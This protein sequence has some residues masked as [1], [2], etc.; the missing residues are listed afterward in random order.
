MPTPGYTFCSKAPCRWTYRAHGLHRLST[1]RTCHRWAR[2]RH[3]RCQVRL[4]AS[5]PRF[6]SSTGGDNRHDRPRVPTGRLPR[7]PGLRMRWRSLPPSTRACRSPH[8]S[9]R[10]RNHH[11]SSSSVSVRLERTQRHRACCWSICAGCASTLFWSLHPL[12][13][14]RPCRP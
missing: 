6:G 2:R 12:C 14:C 13:V 4:A 5:R 3:T 9:G 11:I 8:H 10:L 7:I 1:R